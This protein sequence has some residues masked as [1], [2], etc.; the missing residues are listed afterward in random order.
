MAQ[1]IPSVPVDSGPSLRQRPATGAT[2]PTV[3]ASAAARQVEQAV[4][5][6][7]AILWSSSIT[8]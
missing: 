6:G 5:D 8:A 1:K 7:A 3:E 4:V 2:D